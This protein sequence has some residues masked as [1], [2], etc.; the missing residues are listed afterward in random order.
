MRHRLITVMY[1]LLFLVFLSLTGCAPS[2]ATKPE[3]KSPSQA[4]VADRREGRED[5]KGIRD[6]RAPTS[7]EALRRGEPA[8]GG[9]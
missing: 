9:L 1:G 8:V 2:A 4:S 5:D 7:L 3:A 6:T